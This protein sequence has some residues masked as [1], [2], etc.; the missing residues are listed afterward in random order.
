MNKDRRTSVPAWVMNS[1]LVAPCMCGRP[2]D[3]E[4][5]AILLEDENTGLKRWC[6]LPCYALLDINNDSE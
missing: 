4:I 5:P 3:P 6:H 2:F 1:N